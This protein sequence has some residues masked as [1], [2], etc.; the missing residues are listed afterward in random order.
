MLQRGGKVAEFL[1][2]FRAKISSWPFFR[3]RHRFD[4][5]EHLVGLDLFV[6]RGEAHTLV[7]GFV[8]LLKFRH[9]RKEPSKVSVRG[10]WA[11]AASK[12]APRT[13]PQ[14]GALT[15]GQF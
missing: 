8:A 5:L 14:R 10:S 6:V 12:R 3:S 13:T 15:H 4:L 1:L 7:E 9:I 11:A 2:R